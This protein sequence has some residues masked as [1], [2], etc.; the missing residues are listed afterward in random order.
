[1]ATNIT[2][3]DNLVSFEGTIDQMKIKTVSLLIQ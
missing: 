3:G 2:I 1:M